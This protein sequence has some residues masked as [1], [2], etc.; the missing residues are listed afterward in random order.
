MKKT[1]SLLLVLLLLTSLLSGLH[2]AAEEAAPDALEIYT[3]TGEAEP[4]LVKAYTLAELAELKE[5][6]AEG[7]SYVYWKGEDLKTVV[8]TE[9]VTLDALL[10]DAGATFSAGDELKFTCSDGP[11]PKGDF[12]YESMAERGYDAGGSAV[13]SAIALTCGNSLGAQENTGKLC[14]VC[15]ATAAE[16]EAK[17]A[18]GARMPS[19]VVSVTIVKAEQIPVNPFEDVK[20]SAYYYDA[21]MW[22]VRNGITSGTSDTAFSPKKTCTR[23]EAVAFLWRAAGSPEP[24]SADHPF[25]DVKEGKYYD[26]AVLWAAEKKITSGTSATAFSPNKTCT[27]AEIVT[28][29]WRSAGSPK[30]TGTENPFG[31]V[32]EGAFYCDAVLWA[33]ENKIT[34]GTSA[35][36]FSP[37][38]TCTRAEIVT[39]LFRASATK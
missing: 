19:D 2:A 4:E 14:F 7:Y 36:A 11:Y 38:K 31:D 20:E 33:V 9:L 30:P 6:K 32:K 16:L 24:A 17:N 28:F 15:G 34:E 39:F 22:A 5:T 35:A 18:A 1:I 12:R 37:N 10:A 3:K 8:A 27:R 25:A 23:A 29:L 13:P 21:V 26:T